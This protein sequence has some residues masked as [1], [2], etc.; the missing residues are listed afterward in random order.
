MAARTVGIVIVCPLHWYFSEEHLA[1]VMT[2]MERCGPPML[3][4]HL[5]RASGVFL[6]REGTHRI[7]AA[8]RIGLVPILVDGPWWRPRQRLDNARIAAARRGLSF[9]AVDLR[10]C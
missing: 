6:L 7:R 4:G 8:H 9:H 5:D 10:V 3:R 1:A 2:E